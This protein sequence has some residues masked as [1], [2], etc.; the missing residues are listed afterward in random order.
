VTEEEKEQEENG[1]GHDDMES[2]ELVESD[3]NDDAGREGEKST[4]ST[5]IQSF[6]FIT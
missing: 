1:H 2:E 5:G 3:Y 4:D 6:L